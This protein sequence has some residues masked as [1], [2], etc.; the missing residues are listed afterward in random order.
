MERNYIEDNGLTAV[1]RENKMNGRTKME[2]RL[3]LYW[4][5]IPVGKENA[6]SYSELKIMW[7]KKERDV[8]FILHELSAFDNG[9][10]YILIRSAKKGGGFY[11]TDNPDDIK[12]YRDEC[13]AKGRSTFA[14][15]KKINRVLNNNIDQISMINNLR[16][17]RES[18]GLKQS[19]VCD[20]MKPF[21][22]GFD[23][24][25]LS[26][27]ENGVCMPTLMQCCRLAEIYG[28]TTADLI[29]YDVFMG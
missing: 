9:D 27:M 19:E 4:S 3:E 20:A 5:E 17:V 13:L 11:R 16:T 25:L 22:G 15:I 8:R 23:V 26:K 6:V 7:D 14:P 24:P 12:A 10:D 1:Y 21:D 29:N 18:V 28:C 2:N